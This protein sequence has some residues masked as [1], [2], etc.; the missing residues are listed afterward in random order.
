MAITNI[1]STI[2]DN[3]VPFTI[4]LGV[5]V[6]VH[7]LGHFVVARLCGVR[8][9]VFSL[10]FGKKILSY[11]KGDTVY[12]ISLIPLGGYVK[13]YGEQPGDEI[14]DNLKSVSFTHKN[15]WQRIAI[16]LAGP[17]MNLFFAVLVFG[18]IFYRGEDVRSARLAEIQ[19]GSVAEKSGLQSLDKVLKIN[20]QSVK[21]YEE[22]QNIFNENINK[23]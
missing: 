19:P 1:L 13:M 21:T 12:C 7:E 20:D 8:V 15:V 16:V 17:L 4:L 10:G 5:L 23:K 11:K 14:P 3:I 2:F 22:L 9:E 6:F 18:F